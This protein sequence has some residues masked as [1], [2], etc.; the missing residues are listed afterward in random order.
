M[1]HQLSLR[2]QKNWTPNQV[3]TVWSCYI[4]VSLTTTVW[5][6]GQHRVHLKPRL[7]LAPKSQIHTSRF[8]LLNL[9]L[10]SHSLPRTHACGPST[11]VHGGLF[12]QSIWVWRF[13]GTLK[14]SPPSRLSCVPSP[15]THPGEPG[16]GVQLLYQLCFDFE[17]SISK[18]AADAELWICN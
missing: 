15:G 12:V 5:V 16:E 14:S 18:I 8:R 9:C 1:N 2:F 11:H 10:S 3:L 13:P 7:C 6:C 17:E 4:P